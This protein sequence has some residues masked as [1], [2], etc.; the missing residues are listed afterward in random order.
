MGI[1][2]LSIGQ[3]CHPRFRLTHPVLAGSQAWTYLKG[4]DWV[5]R[6]GQQSAQ[7]V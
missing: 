3:A 1:V 4:V 5:G 6:D 2:S 7:S